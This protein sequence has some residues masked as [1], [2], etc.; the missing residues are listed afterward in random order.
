MLGLLLGWFVWG[1]SRRLLSD[2]IVTMINRLTASDIERQ[3]LLDELSVAPHSS[4][5]RVELS[6]ETPAAKSPSHD[7]MVVLDELETQAGLEHV[8]GIGPKI[9][10]LLAAEG[11]NNLNR[12]ANLSDGAIEHLAIRL[13][14][15]AERVRREGWREQAQELLNGSLT[16][17]EQIADHA[18]GSSP[19]DFSIEFEKPDA[20]VAPDL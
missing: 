1:R 14:A 15:V 16:K 12:L 10:V 11:I 20:A 7:M 9:A 6:D 17:G 5:V 13:P 3:R 19:Q 4:N 18:S 2:Q 8:R